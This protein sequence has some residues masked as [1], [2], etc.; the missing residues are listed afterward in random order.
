MVRGTAL[1]LLCLLAIASSA[2]AQTHPAGFED[3]MVISGLNE[4]TALVQTPDGKLLVGLRGGVIRV[5]LPNGTMLPK[6]MLSITVHTYEET[7]LLG[8]ALHPQYPTQ[9][10]L[11]VFHTPSPGTVSRVT[12][13]VLAADTVVAGSAQVM[14]GDLPLGDGYHLGSCV[15]TSSD[16]YLWISTGDTG[17]AAQ[18]YPQQL[19]RLEGKLLRLNLDGSIPTDNPF[20]GVGGARGEIYQLGLRNPFRFTIQPG[21]GEP[22][23]SDVGQNS[24]EEIDHG[25]PGANFGWPTYEGSV[26]P[27]PQG[28][29]NPIH[30]Y[31]NGGNAS[32]TGCV[33]Y[34]G[35][36]FPAEYQGNFFFL[37]HSRGQIGRMVLGQANELISVNETWATTQGEGWGTGPVDLML[38]LDGALYY[39]QFSGS[40]IRRL[41]YGPLVGV[42][43]IP[44]PPS[45]SFDAPRPNPMS[46]VVALHF[47]LPAI[48]R[49]RLTVHD[50][51]GRLV[52]LLCDGDRSAG[53][54]SEAWDGSDDAGNLTAPGLYFARLDAGGRTLTQ[55][56]I[57]VR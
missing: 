29:T 52:R 26:T 5:I 30:D 54:H 37:D 13:Y 14:M 24:K 4:P 47:A 53:P 49:T 48:G 51:Q 45:V 21:T 22:F 55:R 18:G 20:V 2:V 39:T 40:Q 38:G 16:G 7:G 10:F 33:F 41:R 3:E 31:D 12:R 44:V 19:N 23:I 27:Q 57:R 9:P 15:R 25:A 56:I 17:R 34:T 11:Y 35:A 43:P 32:I 50:V 8:L 6:A 1:A 46:D 42:D 28:I 36:N